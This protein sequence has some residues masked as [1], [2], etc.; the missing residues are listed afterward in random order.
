M[1]AAR[2]DRNRVAEAIGKNPVD[3]R[4]HFVSTQ[5]ADTETVGN[6]WHILIEGQAIQIAIIT[7]YRQREV[8]RRRCGY[9]AILH[10]GLQVVVCAGDVDEQWIALHDVRAAGQRR[11]VIRQHI[12]HVEIGIATQA[13][14]LIKRQRARF[15]NDI[16]EHVK[17]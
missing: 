16:V 17:V 10:I 11:S 4:L 6:L 14:R 3:N 12:T 7:G 8:D 2:H 15:V 13:T 1:R 5:I 9:D